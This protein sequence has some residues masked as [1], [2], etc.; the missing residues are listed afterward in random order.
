MPEAG[1]AR[2]WTH[3]KHSVVGWLLSQL[4]LLPLNLAEREAGLEHVNPS[5]PL[6]SQHLHPCDCAR[7]TPGCFLPL[8]CRKPC[9]LMALGLCLCC[10]LCQKCPVLSTRPSEPGQPGLW[11]HPADKSLPEFCAHRAKWQLSWCGVRVYL[12]SDSTSG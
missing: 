6:L 2:C 5:P 8:A 7:T 10:A 12:L 3:R 9:S 11:E 4:L 1:L